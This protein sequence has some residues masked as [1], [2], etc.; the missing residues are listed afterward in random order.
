MI[1][2]QVIKIENETGEVKNFKKRKL[3]GF[4]IS[5]QDISTF[6]NFKS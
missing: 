2:E 3:K 5:L 1:D 6:L 4:Y